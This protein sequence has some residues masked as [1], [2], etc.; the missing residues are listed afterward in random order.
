MLM[1]QTRVTLLG[2]FVSTHAELLKEHHLDGSEKRFELTTPEG[3]KLTNT[4]GMTTAVRVAIQFETIEHQANLAVLVEEGKNIKRLGETGSINAFCTIRSNR[5]G[6]IPHVCAHACTHIP[7]THTYTDGKL[8][9]TRT[10][11]Q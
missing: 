11:T 3:D 1:F 4:S 10:H 9:Q 2:E 7:C 6:T 8:L 5:C